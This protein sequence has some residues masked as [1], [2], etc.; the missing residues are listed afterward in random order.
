MGFLELPLAWLDPVK[1]SIESVVKALT[2]NVNNI[3]LND[4]KASGGSMIVVE[5]QALTGSTAR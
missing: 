3:L 4:S 2:R 5:N 1:M